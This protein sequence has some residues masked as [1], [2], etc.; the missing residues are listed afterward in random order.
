MYVR[1]TG[2]HHFGECSTCLADWD[3]EM[4]S[5]YDFKFCPYCG[6]RQEYSNVIS[7]ESENK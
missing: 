3:S 2:P 1:N 7:E 6:E 5:E 4:I